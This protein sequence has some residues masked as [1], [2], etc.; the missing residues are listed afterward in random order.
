MCRSLA[1]LAS[2]GPPKSDGTP[3]QTPQVGSAGH[4]RAEKISKA[5]KAYLERAQSHGGS[6]TDKTLGTCVE[7]G[8]TSLLP[9]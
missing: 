5:M 8:P 2:D 6:P 9:L 4:E 1:S 3:N 7:F